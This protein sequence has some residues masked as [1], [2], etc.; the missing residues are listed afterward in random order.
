MDV[1]ADYASV[2]VAAVAQRLDFQCNTCYH[3]LKLLL[4]TDFTT[5]TTITY[6]SLF[7]VADLLKFVVDNHH[8]LD[9]STVLG[10][11]VAEAVVDDF[12]KKNN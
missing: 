6:C 1:V 4:H 11:L 9:F 10:Q 8:E 3:R 2:A 12:L 5:T 7:V